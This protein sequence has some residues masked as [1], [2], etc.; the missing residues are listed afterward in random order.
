MCRQYFDKVCKNY[1]SKNKDDN[2]RELANE[3]LK[4]GWLADVILN[5]I[6]RYTEDM[7]AQLY[8]IKYNKKNRTK[9]MIE[10]DK[11]MK[12]FRENINKRVKKEKVK[13]E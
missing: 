3:Q 4:I 13:K 12:Q 5:I 2:L 8:K 6:R 11:K 10:S 9:E 1:N 7:E